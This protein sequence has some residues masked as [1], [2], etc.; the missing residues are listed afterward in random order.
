MRTCSPVEPILR[1]QFCLRYFGIQSLCGLFAVPLWTLLWPEED[2][3]PVWLFWALF[4]LMQLRCRIESSL[5][6]AR[7]QFIHSRYNGRPR[8]AFIFRRTDEVKLKAGFE[9]LLVMVT[10]VLLMPVSQPLGSYLL[11]AGFCL[12]VNHA[13]IESVERAR[14]MEIHDAMLEQQD[15][16]A[17]VRDMQRGRE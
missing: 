6:A 4:V 12:L 10:G 15:L 2:P 5:M 7:G 8:L 3:L 1:T 14:A 13:A 17:R 16:A 11:V 9:P